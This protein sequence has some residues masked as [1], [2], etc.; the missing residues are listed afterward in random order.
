[1]LAS[2]PE[3]TPLEKGNG[4]CQLYSFQHLIGLIG[5]PLKNENVSITRDPPREIGLGANGS[6]S[7]DLSKI[8]K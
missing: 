3:L 6:T 4:L 8:R 7:W 1:M 5:I 2:A